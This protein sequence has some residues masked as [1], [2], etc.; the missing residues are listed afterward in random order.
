MSVRTTLYITRAA[1]EGFLLQYG[2]IER[3]EREELIDCG[4]LDVYDAIGELSDEDLA[5]VLDRFV[6]YNNFIVHF[7]APEDDEIEALRVLEF[8][9]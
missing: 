8:G 9:W 3:I 6:T 1:A 4:D 5:D 2:S 7:S